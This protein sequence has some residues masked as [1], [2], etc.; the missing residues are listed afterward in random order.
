MK[1]PKSCIAS[2]RGHGPVRAKEVFPSGN[3]VWRIPADTTGAN[4]GPGEIFPRPFGDL[5]KRLLSRKF[6]VHLGA[7]P[8]GGKGAAAKTL[9]HGHFRSRQRGL[10]SRRGS[11]LDDSGSRLSLGDK[12]WPRFGGK[13][14]FPGNRAGSR[15]FGNR[16]TGRV[17]LVH[18]VHA[19]Y[20]GARSGSGDSP[21]GR[22]CAG[23][24]ASRHDS[25]G[26]H[27]GGG[28]L[29]SGLGL[30]QGYYFSVRAAHPL[31]DAEST[32]PSIAPP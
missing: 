7:G 1:L 18:G 21:A 5:G 23:L 31:R 11:G 24:G 20:T 3:P 15:V 14:A 27:V 6:S 28:R 12:R 17:L 8:F 9:R 22:T 19:A 32:S 10:R 30:G 4:K 25:R 2:G 29:G 26:M 16:L 13:T